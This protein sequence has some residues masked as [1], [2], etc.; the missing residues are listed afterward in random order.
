MNLLIRPLCAALAWLLLAPA[1]AQV[2][3]SPLG[4]P[5]APPAATGGAAAGAAPAAVPQ[6]PA[7][8]Q[9]PGVHSPLSPFAPLKPRD[10]I[11]AWP[12]LTDLKTEVK[13]R[14]IV[15]VY[16]AAVNALNQKT[17]RVQGFMLPLSPGEQQRHFLLASVPPTCQFCTP[18]GPES[19]VEV[20]T[21][22]PVKYSLGAVVVEGKFHVLQNDPYGL[23]YRMTEAVGVK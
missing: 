7:Q 23:Y 2:L 5:S 20:R 14:R 19:M 12:V 9:G 11:V 8:G 13:N 1:S 16:P 4:T 6:S 17:Q 18:G 3:T 15:P 21:R 22:E 10:D